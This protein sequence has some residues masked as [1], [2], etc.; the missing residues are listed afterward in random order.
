MCEGTRHHFDRK[1]VIVVARD[2]VSTEKALELAIESGAEDVHEAED[3]EEKPI[4]QVT[5]NRDT[6]FVI[7]KRKE[8]LKT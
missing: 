4:L 7:N 8:V 6:C 2:Q 3:E 1:G 5:I